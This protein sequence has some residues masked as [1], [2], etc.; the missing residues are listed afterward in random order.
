MPFPQGFLQLESLNGPEPGCPDDWWNFKKVVR[1]FEYVSGD[2]ESTVV[3]AGRFIDGASVPRILWPFVGSPF[4]PLAMTG[5]IHDEK[6][7]CGH[8]R[9]IADYT[10]S[11]VARETPAVRPY[12]RRLAVIGLRLFGW[13]TWR[14]YRGTL[15]WPFKN[16]DRKNEDNAD[17]RM[18][19]SDGG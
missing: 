10:F 11:A 18:R 12:Q 13:Y 1:D 4:G 6:Y 17:D 15:P 19:F 3:R 5:A 16:A 7:R 14:K 2:G 9:G 8:N